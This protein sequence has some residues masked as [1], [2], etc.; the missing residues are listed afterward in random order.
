M[1][2]GLPPPTPHPRPALT[3]ACCPSACISLC[4]RAPP[5]SP[6][7]RPRRPPPRPSRAHPL[8]PA[9]R[10]LWPLHEVRQAGPP[11]PLLQ[12]MTEVLPR[13]TPQ[14]QLLAK[15][16]RAGEARTSGVPA[17]GLRPLFPGDLLADWGPSGA[18]RRDYAGRRGAGGTARPPAL[19][20]GWSDGGNLKKPQH[21]GSPT[22]V[23]IPEANGKVFLPSSAVL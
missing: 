11:F 17:G 18:P 15:P 4:A 23:P 10:R 13:R 1:E 19:T 5:A 16:G 20:R 2:L 14:R 9:N 12:I 8:A 22:N 6:P 7:C 3:P 21:H